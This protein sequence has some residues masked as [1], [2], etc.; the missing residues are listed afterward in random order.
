MASTGLD[1]PQKMILYMQKMILYMQRILK[2]V[3]LVAIC[4]FPSVFTAL[5]RNILAWGV[6][7][8]LSQLGTPQRRSCLTMVSEQVKTKLDFFSE[9]AYAKFF[10]LN[11]QLLTVHL[12]S[13]LLLSATTTLSLVGY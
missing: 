7:F 1:G 12:L 8:V 4:I 13:T 2:S 11:T 6:R 3:K 5:S 9:Q 10:F